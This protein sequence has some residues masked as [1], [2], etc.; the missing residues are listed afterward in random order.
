MLVTMLILGIILPIINAL[1]ANKLMDQISF[2]RN[3]S[4]IQHQQEYYKQPPVPSKL[5]RYP[6]KE[7]FIS[8][9]YYPSRE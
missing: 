9:P 6:L 7:E 3:F 4:D 8:P 5:S 1:E 2:L